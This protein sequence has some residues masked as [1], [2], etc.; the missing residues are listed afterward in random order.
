MAKVLSTTAFFRDIKSGTPISSEFFVIRH[1]L[2]SACQ[3]GLSLARISSSV[4]FVSGVVLHDLTRARI[5]QKQGLQ[6][7]LGHLELA[8]LTMFLRAMGGPQ[9]N[10]HATS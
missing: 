8:L 3:R 2:T 7:Q 1:C 4:A 6:T 10:S 5:E 9:L